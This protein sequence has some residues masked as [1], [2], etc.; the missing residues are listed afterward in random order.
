MRLFREKVRPTFTNSTHNIIQVKDYKEIFFDVY[1]IEINKTKYPVDKIASFEGNP[2]VSIPVV[3]EGIEKHYPFVLTQG[4]FEVFFNEENTIDQFSDDPDVISEKTIEEISIIEEN[5]DLPIDINPIVEIEEEPSN[6]IFEQIEKARKEASRK[7]R[8]YSR[9][10]KKE[11][12]EEQVERGRELRKLL[13]ETKDYLTE[14]FVQI[15]NNIR[16]ELYDG[17]ESFKEKIQ[18]SLN[19]KIEKYSIHLGEYVEENLESSLEEF[20]KSLISLVNEIDENSLKPKIN[21]GLNEIRK[22]LENRIE[23]IRES[24]ENELST[25]REDHDKKINKA[26]SR[27]G[28]VSTKIDEAESRI[29]DYYNEKLEI[30]EKRGSS[31]YQEIKKLVEESR[32][33]LLLEI[34]K[35]KNEPKF[36]YVLESTESKK[37][38]KKQ[39]NDIEK[40]IESKL[41]SELAK[42]RKQLKFY[43]SSGGGT[44]AQQFANGGVMN[45]DLIVTGTLSASNFG[46]GIG[47][48]SPYHDQTVFTK[49][50]SLGENSIQ[51]FPLNNDYDLV[52]SSFTIVISDPLKKNSL[53]YDC[54]INNGVVVGSGYSVLNNGGVMYSNLDTFLSAGY[55]YVSLSANT[56]AELIILGDGIY[57]PSIEYDGDIFQS[58]D[59]PLFISEQIEIFTLE[60]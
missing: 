18:K 32:T 29:N 55:L 12:E 40:K 39:Q 43:S 52:Q 9:K 58:E 17:N 1:E 28:T 5:I 26:L 33:N 30:L 47:S 6:Q 57:E 49:L 10:K 11:L 2:V 56:T 34:D 59:G 13:N 37:V 46:G 4:E 35:I 51:T 48:T 45:G 23:H 16:D 8:V 38:S 14:E 36:D 19:E 15:S 41:D 31:N 44:V 21:K 25:L 24:Q 7:I 53:K 60:D 42:L 27:I 22:V 50:L 20:E 54:V 3:K